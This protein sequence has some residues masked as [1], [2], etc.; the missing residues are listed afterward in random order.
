[1]K[2]LFYHP[3]A[4]REI[5]AAHDW[6][7]QQS[8]N[9]AEGFYEELIPALDRLQIQPGLYPQHIHGTQ[10]L[11]L[12]RYPFSVIFRERLDDIQVIAVAHAK[13]KP[14]YWSKRI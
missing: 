2:Q 10:R 14:G 13:R 1:M 3:A 4:R 9:A 6:Y 12:S 11:V 7:L 5:L 8:A